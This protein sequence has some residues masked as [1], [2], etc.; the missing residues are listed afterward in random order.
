M[1]I[2]SALKE[3]LRAGKPVVGVSFTFPSPAMMEMCAYAGFHFARID[4]E[5]GPMDPIAAEHMVRAAE[6]TG[7]TPIVRV[8]VNA[9]HEILRYLD[10]GA[11]G[12][13]VPHIETRADAEAAARS[14]RFHPRGE[15]GLAGA[16]WAGFGAVRPL[17]QLI[18]EANDAMLLMALIE[19][20]KG[21]DNLDEILAVTDVDAVQIGPADLSQSLGLA[22]QITHPVVQEH[23][24]RVID[25]SLAAGKY[26]A[27]GARD[28]QAARELI[29]R[30]VQIVEL[31][32]SQIF[33]GAGRAF[34]RDLALD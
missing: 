29:D 16:R 11:Q 4:C 32:A 24:D 8:P 33:L 17:D 26:V 34:L 1:I 30:G 18:A 28:L 22:A 3:R 14:V 13:L 25:K 12:V 21:V 2:A 31:S 23:I 15:R 6:A 19:S 10:T 20:A 7:I 5:H 27:F 9:S